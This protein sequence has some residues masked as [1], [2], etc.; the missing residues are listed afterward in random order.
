MK[1]LAGLA[2]LSASMSV[3]QSEEGELRQ[4]NDAGLG[5]ETWNIRRRAVSLNYIAVYGF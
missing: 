3:Q 1:A 4:H 2:R 5:K